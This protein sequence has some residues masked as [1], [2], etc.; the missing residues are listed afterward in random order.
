[1]TAF[2][3]RP[4]SHTASPYIFLDATY[5]KARV[6]GR[7]VSRAVV[8]ATGVTADGGREVLGC[9]VGDSENG[10]FWTAFLR[11]LKTLCGCRWV[12][13]TI[14]GT[15]GTTATSRCHPFG[16]CRGRGRSFQ[17]REG[18]QDGSC[19][20]ALPRG[21]QY[22]RPRAVRAVR[23]ALGVPEQWRERRFRAGLTAEMQSR[24]DAG[25]TALVLGFFASAWFGW[26]QAAPPAGLGNWLTVGS[27]LAL[28]VPAVGT[29]VGF[30]SPASTAALHDR[31]AGGAMATS[32]ASSS[33]RPASVRLGR[34]GHAQH[35]DRRRRRPASAG[36]RHRRARRCPAE[37]RMPGST[38]DGLVERV[39]GR[40][41]PA[42][43]R[44]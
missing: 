30:R 21:A 14:C 22:P 4:L 3:S 38:A 43:G 12:W 17:V 7:V 18:Y 34:P 11:S 33:G 13:R 19:T 5:V 24:R 2:R 29:F 41:R 16:I 42:T 28:A 20:R 39:R 40:V 35:R 36:L 1:V 9:E 6:D 10:A 15:F 31:A 8:I 25:I 44:C 26:G 37:Q 27:L 23:I 32:W